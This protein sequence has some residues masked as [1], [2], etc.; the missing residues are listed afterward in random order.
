[1]RKVCLALLVAVL[2]GGVAR[3]AFA[4]QQFYNVFKEVYLTDHENEEF[5]KAASNP[6]TRCFVCHQ[7]KIKRNRNAYGV[8]ISKLLN[9][10]DAKN[11]EKIKAALAEVGAMHSDPEDETS[12]TYDELI[13]AGEFP[14]GKL[15]DLGKEPPKKP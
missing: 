8:Q 14:G 7:G 3:P 12:L 6:K 13:A 10:K 5:L 9:K 2:A 1:M 11:V 4:V 15:E